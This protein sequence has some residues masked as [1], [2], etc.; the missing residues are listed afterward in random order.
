MCCFSLVEGTY[1]STQ[2]C[3]SMNATFWHDFAPHNSL[4]LRWNVVEAFGT[5]P[6]KPNQVALQVKQSWP[7]CHEM[8]SD[9]I[10]CIALR[11]W[12]VYLRHAIS[13]LFTSCSIIL[14]FVSIGLRVFGSQ[15]VIFRAKCH[16]IS[17]GRNKYRR[18]TQSEKRTLD[19]DLG[20]F[21][22]PP[23]S[24]VHLSV[25]RLAIHPL[26]LRTTMKS[27]RPLVAC[28]FVLQEVV[29]LM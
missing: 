1:R 21:E 5:L 13:T 12:L 4:R 15:L 22:A 20:Q 3:S 17:D 27:R 23:T 11:H 29:T 28:W 10:T 8:V 25:G 24:S 14:V 9:W 16:S 6:T 18:K 26:P 7:C 2:S 19:K